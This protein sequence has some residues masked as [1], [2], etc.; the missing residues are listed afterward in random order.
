MKMKD[1][2]QSQAKSSKR[3]EDWEEFK[4]TRNKVTGRLKVEKEEWQNKTLDHCNND[5]GRTFW[6]G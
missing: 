5:S 3:E 6:G 2:L 4:K 1:S